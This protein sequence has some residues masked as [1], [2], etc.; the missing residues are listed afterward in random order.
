MIVRL[1]CHGRLQSITRTVWESVSYSNC[2]PPQQDAKK[3]SFSRRMSISRWARSL[4]GILFCFSSS[5]ERRCASFFM[6]CSTASSGSEF[7]RRTL[8]S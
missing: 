8:I 7:L 5:A 6:L 1:C 2:T 3:I 4:R